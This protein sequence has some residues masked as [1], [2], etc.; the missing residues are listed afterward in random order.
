NLPGLVAAAQRNF[1]LTLTEE[2]LNGKSLQEITETVSQGV[3]K[4]YDQQKAE[5]GDFFEQLGRMLMLQTIDQRWKEHLE[6]IDHL[7]EGIHLRAHAQKDPL[8]EYKK[9]AFSAFQE[10]NSWIYEETVE[11]LMKIRLVNQERAREVLQDRQEL[12]LSELNYAGADENAAFVPQVQAPRAA[13]A[14]LPGQ[15]PSPMEFNYGPVDG[16]GPQL[17]REQR[18]RQEKKAK[19]KKLKI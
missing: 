18:R 4:I 10:M 3:K 11:K 19:K 6:R 9:E 15:A 12:D 7:K 14:G 5:I 17:N 16:D 1:G 2:Q 13:P 8:I